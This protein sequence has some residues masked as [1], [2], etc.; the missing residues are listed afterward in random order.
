[1]TDIFDATAYLDEAVDILEIA[2]REDYILDYYDESE[3]AEVYSWFESILPHR[4][5]APR[6][7]KEGLQLAAEVEGNDEDAEDDRNEFIMQPIQFGNVR[8]LLEA[9]A[10]EF[11]RY[12]EGKETGFWGISNPT[13]EDI[14][15]AWS[16]YG[17][18]LQ[19]YV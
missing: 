18:T 9:M 2:D 16:V 14:S 15:V 4:R 10:F 7:L 8:T 5:D 6:L 12:V 17:N 13:E 19:Y 3:L 1:M 11:E